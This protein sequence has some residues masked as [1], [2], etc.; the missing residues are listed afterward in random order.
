MFSLLAPSFDVVIVSFVFLFKPVNLTIVCVKQNSMGARE[1]GGGRGE[2]QSFIASVDGCDI[3]SG[4][5]VI[6]DYDTTCLPGSQS[7]ECHVGT[8]DM[9]K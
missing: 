3:E 8:F 5:N 6:A 1:E 4:E 7:A 9:F 2:G